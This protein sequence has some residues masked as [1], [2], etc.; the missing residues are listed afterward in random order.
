MSSNHPGPYAGPP[1]QPGPYGVQQPGPY[2]PPP[3]QPGPYGPPG[4]PGPY[5]Q[6][7]HP[8]PYAPPGQPGP[9]GPPQQGGWGWPPQQGGQPPQRSGAGKKAGIV[10][11]V[12]VALAAIGGTLFWYIGSKGVKDDGPHKL[13]APSTTSFGT[14]FR[15]GDKSDPTLTGADTQ[16]L[17]EIGIENPE[18]VVASYYEEYLGN[19]DGSDP[20]EVQDRLRSARNHAR[21][22]VSGAYGKIADPK[23]ALIQYF[24]KTRDHLTTASQ[25]GSARI[26]TML[27]VA[28]ETEADSLDGAVMMCADLDIDNYETS[29]DS[30]TTVC[31]WADYSTIGLVTPYNGIL[32]LTTPEAAELTGKVRGDLRVAG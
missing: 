2:G 30:R 18:P 24:A 32:G 10:V 29:E 9:F 4:Q 31:G 22:T 7:G 11:G 12:A 19:L 6:P 17:E 28:E 16:E 14:Y 5:G 8:A 15:Y 25:K 26:F 13:T 1:Q 27:G 3:G 20:D 23:L 21:F